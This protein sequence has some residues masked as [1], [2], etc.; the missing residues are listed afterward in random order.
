MGHHNQFWNHIYRKH[1]AG[2]QQVCA[3]YVG[4][5]VAAEDVVQET[6]LRAMAGYHTYQGKGPL[7][8]WLR[9]IAVNTALMHLRKRKRNPEESLQ[10]EEL[11]QLSVDPHQ[12]EPTTQIGRA[13]V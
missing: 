4:P 2:L 5:G 1:H 7:E 13:H 8:A 6:F 12:E 11:P 3:R 9:R 10:S